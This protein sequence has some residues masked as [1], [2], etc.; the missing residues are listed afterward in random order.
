MKKA[1]DITWK[2]H[3]E[4]QN[5]IQG[6]FNEQEIFT[7]KPM[8]KNS[9]QYNLFSWGFRNE[10]FNHSTNSKNL[11]TFLSIESAKSFAEDKWNS[12]VNELIII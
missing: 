5:E 6:I 9:N 7:I 1:K 2:N 10:T 12:F 4:F 11:G 8:N 3:P